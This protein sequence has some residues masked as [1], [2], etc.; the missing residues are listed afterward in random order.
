MLWLFRPSY[1]SSETP[2][3]PILPTSPRTAGDI[4]GD[5]GEWYYA[6]LNNRQRSATV[7]DLKREAWAEIEKENEIKLQKPI[8]SQ[9]QI[10]PKVKLIKKDEF[11][12]TDEELLL[13]WWKLRN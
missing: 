5:D 2:L 3:P 11:K 9:K 10:K 12:F 7:E 8:I 13:A 1:S 6:P 4:G